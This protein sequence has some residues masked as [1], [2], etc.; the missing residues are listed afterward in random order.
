MF[1]RE[2]RTRFDALRKDG[3]VKQ[4]VKTWKLNADKKNT[5]F[6]VGEIAYAR[7]YRDPDTQRWIKAKILRRKGENIYECSAAEIGT[8]V[9]RTHQLLKYAYDDYDNDDGGIRTEAVQEQNPAPAPDDDYLSA[10]DDE[11]LV[12][13]QQR[14]HYREDGAYVTRSNRVVRVPDRL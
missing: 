13:V 7:D 14:G 10:E 3:V 12:P 5:S 9:R 8:F 11:D 1:G 2:M 6:D 4:T